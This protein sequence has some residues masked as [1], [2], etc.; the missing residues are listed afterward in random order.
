M[1]KRKF[2]LPETKNMFKLAGLAT[3][4]QKEKFIEAKATK[5][6]KDM[7]M[8][9]FG[10]EV[11]PDSTVYVGLNGIVKD[12]VCFYKKSEVKGQKGTSKKIPWA[13]KD[14]FAEEGF[15]L[16]GMNVG[17]TKKLNEKGLEVNDTKTLTEY[18]ACQE[19]ADNLKDGD[20]IFVR[21]SIDFSSF[22]RD[23]GTISRSTKF[24][25][26]QVSLC[27]PIDFEAEDFTQT[28]DFQQVLIYIDNELDNTDPE[29]KKGKIIA[30]VVTYGS[31][32]DAEFIIRD[33]KLFGMFKKNLKPYTAIKVWGNIHNKVVKEEVSSDDV[34]GSENNFDKVNKTHIR[35]LVIVGADP[36]TIDKETYSEAKINEALRA[37]REFGEDGTSST[38]S[39]GDGAGLEEDGND[40]W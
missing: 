11:A 34:W 8:L 12:E 2:D 33:Q 7:L 29:D 30:K 15:K 23:D 26:N 40:G 6:G 37:L 1:A 14:K 18:D 35:E 5:S 39:W 36:K 24:V 17:V 38:D 22:K 16:L 21:G 25:P 31:I 19:I 27:K 13:N 20:S 28:A 10:V 32:E 4:T 9:N 3:A